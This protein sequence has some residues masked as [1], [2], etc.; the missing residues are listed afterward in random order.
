[1]EDSVGL[2]ILLLPPVHGVD[3]PNPLC[4]SAAHASSVVAYEL[5][6]LLGDILE[7]VDLRQDLPAIY[8]RPGMFINNDPARIEQGT[9][10]PATARGLGRLLK[11]DSKRPQELG[12]TNQRN[13]LQC[14]VIPLP[15][16]ELIAR[17]A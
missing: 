14:C 2:P 3:L 16:R 7:Y 12:F 4:P 1:M 13:L 6:G 11:P 5:R 17:I 10:S 9:A 15:A 8:L